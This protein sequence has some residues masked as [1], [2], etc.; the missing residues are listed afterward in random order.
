MRRP[1]HIHVFFAALLTAPALFPASADGLF[2]GYIPCV[3]S[4]DCDKT[5]TGGGGTTIPSGTDTGTRTRSATSEQPPPTP[6][7]SDSPPD[8]VPD[9]E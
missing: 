8:G 6:T 4:G 3:D 2:E 7:Q 5:G 9:A 1:W